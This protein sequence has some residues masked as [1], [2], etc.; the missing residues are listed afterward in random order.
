[1]KLRR[2]KKSHSECIRLARLSGRYPPISVTLWE[3]FTL[4]PFQ[5][6]KK[7]E[8]KKQWDNAKCLVIRVDRLRLAMSEEWPLL[9][10]KTNFDTQCKLIPSHCDIRQMGKFASRGET[11]WIIRKL[12][13]HSHSHPFFPSLNRTIRSIRNGWKSIVSTHNLIALTLV[14]IPYDELTCPSVLLTSDINEQ[15]QHEWLQQL[16]QRQLRRPCVWSTTHLEEVICFNSLDQPKNW[17]VLVRAKC[18][19]SLKMRRKNTQKNK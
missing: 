16:H 1:M 7:Q 17:L 5:L 9:H 14:A 18:I 3:Y 15:Q 2:E 12:Q 19:G 4:L 11:Y 6:E 8:T 10:N 13:N